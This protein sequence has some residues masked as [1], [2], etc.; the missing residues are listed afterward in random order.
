MKALLTLKKILKQWLAIILVLVGIVLIYNN[1]NKLINSIEMSLLGS[2]KSIMSFSSKI[3]NGIDVTWSTTI[4]EF[5]NL[6]TEYKELK[7][8]NQLLKDSI[9]TFQQLLFE[10]EELRKLNNVT[11]P[12]VTKIATT[13]IVSQ[14]E[15]GYFNTAVIL[16]G[17]NQHIKTGQVVVNGD[18]VI[19]RIVNVGK[20]ISRVLLLTDTSSKIPVFFPRTK[21][22]GVVVGNNNNLLA[23]YLS[24]S[25]KIAIGDLV[26]TSGDG[27]LFPYGLPIGV[28]SNIE[29]GNIMITSFYDPSKL[30]LVSVLSY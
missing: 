17:K 2:A 30:N 10:N 21:E 11:L 28:V 9:L 8:E 6:H 3:T 12:K 19:G 22:H 5:I 14:F 29:K 13:R 25:T 20:E 26:L 7:L 15:S 23:Q 27:M 24:K 18:G 1:N 4:S 16:A